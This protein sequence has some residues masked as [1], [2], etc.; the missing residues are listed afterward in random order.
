VVQDL[1]ARAAVAVVNARQYERD[2]ETALTLQRSLLPQRMPRVPGMELAWRYLP[3][4]E[5]ALVGGDWYDVLPLDGGKV[6]LVIGDVMGRGVQAAGVMGQLRATARAHAAAHLAPEAVLAHLDAAVGRLE[7]GQIST[8]AFAVLDPARRRLTVASAG[9]LPPLLV[10]ARGEP[11]FV[12]V[13]PGPPLGAGR[14]EYRAATVPFGAGSM[15]LL[16]TDGLVEDRVR[17]VDVGMRMLREAAAGAGSAEDLC[18]RA[19]VALGRADGS[20]DDT[21][22]LAVSLMPSAA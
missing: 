13:D 18:E 7:Q 22:L 12:P 5:G 20:D 2:R 17:A 1:A 19:L 6:A 14:P 8:T 4:G 21:A 15:L 16:F 3:A 10:P 9:H 11:A